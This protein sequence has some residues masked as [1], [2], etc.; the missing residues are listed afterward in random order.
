MPWDWRRMKRN[1]M[2]TNCNSVIKLTIPA[3]RISVACK[4]KKVYNLNEIEIARRVGIAQAAVSKYLNGRYSARIGKVRGIVESIGLDAPIVKAL[5][6]A[7]YDR[8]HISLLIDA[9]ALNSTL[10][11][12][13]IKILKLSPSVSK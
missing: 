5:S 10:A 7:G 13:T 2:Y 6:K 11:E 4:L 1:R 8:K 3:L 9:A 12:K